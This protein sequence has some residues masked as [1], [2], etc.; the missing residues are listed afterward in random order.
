MKQE[1]SLDLTSL[2]VDGGMTVNPLLLQL[3]SDLLNMNVERTS[4]TEATALGASI[5]AGLA[6]GVWYNSNF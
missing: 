4:N 1:C 6:V 3:Q 2:R 5:A